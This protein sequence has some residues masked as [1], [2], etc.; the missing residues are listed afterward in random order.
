MILFNFNVTIEIFYLAVILIIIGEAL[1]TFEF[2]NNKFLLLY[3]FIIGI[4]LNF[5]FHGISYQ[6]LFESL[7]SLALSTFIY[8]I[9]K[10]V[11]RDR[12]SIY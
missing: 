5:I 8:D 10:I 6:T 2:I 7:V 12:K 1:K 11:R 4:G 3:L 9:I